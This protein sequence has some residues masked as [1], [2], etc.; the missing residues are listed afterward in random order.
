MRPLRIYI[1]FDPRETVAFNVLAHSIQRRA[2]RPVAITAVSL[3][4]LPEYRR[5]RDPLQSTDFSM[6]RFLVPYLEGYGPEPVLFLD[7]D[8]LALCDVADLFK[9]Y[10]EQYAVQCV[11]H[12]YAPVREDKFLGAQQTLYPKKNWSSV[13]LMQP[14]R[15]RRLTPE[16]VNRATGMQLHQFMWLESD[17]E[18]G[19]LP[20]GYNYLVGEAAQCDLR[21]VKI[22]H[23]TRGGPYFKEYEHCEF[24]RAWQLEEDDMRR[25]D[26]KVAA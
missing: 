20:K 10:D 21:D 3:T 22:V 26:Q 25:C 16:Y 23:F 12:E 11:Q 13:M 24:S 1:G 14:S 4:Q 17:A 9:L 19:A 18:I 5:P 6:S 2:S 8:M 7:C 15:C